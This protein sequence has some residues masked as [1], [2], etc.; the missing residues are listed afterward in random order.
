M[1]VIFGNSSI[2]GTT[3]KERTIY[4][5]EARRDNHQAIVTRPPTS[6]GGPIF[7]SEDAYFVHLPHN[8]DTLIVM[9]HIGCCKVS[10]I[11]ADGE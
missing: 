11:L 10:K 6:P 4:V 5:N 1:N 2:E 9:V 3:T 8:E 7:F